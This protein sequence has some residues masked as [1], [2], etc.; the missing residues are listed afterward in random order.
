MRDKRVLLRLLR[1]LPQHAGHH[2]DGDRADARAEREGDFSGLGTPLL[3][4]A[5]G[6][7]PFPGNQ[8]PAAAI[9]PMARNVLDLY[10][11]GNVSPSIYRET[12]GR[13]E[14]RWIRLGGRVDFNASSNDQVFARY[15]YSG[16]HNLNPISVR[17]TDVP[18]FPTRDD[19]ATH[20]GAGVGDARPL[21]VDDATR[22]RATYLR[23]KFFFDQRLNRTPP[24]A[25]GFGY[26]SS[27]EVGPGAAV[28][29]HQRLHAD[30]RRHH[31]PAQHRRRRTFE[32]QD[33]LTWTRGAHLI[34]VGGE[35]RHTSIDMFQAIA[36]NAFFVFAGTFPTNNAIANLLLG[37]P[38]TFYQGLG[39]FN[40]G[41][42]VWSGGAL[43]AGRVAGR[44]AA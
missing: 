2:D 22:L 5:A 27:N 6:G 43:R 18:G 15:S 38:V 21:A 44:A 37:S 24:S 29:Q 32:I 20:S 14:R 39:D 36:P 40:R 10:P 25:L 30:R 41:V 12:A 17:G 16:G 31:R 3:N 34:K 13:R 28:L 19:L 4:L 35:Y 26:E 8:I 42:R 33:S 11:L 7:T 9:N 1:R 23:H